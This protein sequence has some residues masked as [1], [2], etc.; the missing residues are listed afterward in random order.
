MTTTQA[1]ALPIFREAI[2]RENKQI[3]RKN[4]FKK[5]QKYHVMLQFFW[6]D[7]N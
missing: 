4:S 6:E 2:C 5:W 3:N 1:P 7:I